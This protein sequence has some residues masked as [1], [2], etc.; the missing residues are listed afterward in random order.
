MSADVPPPA[1]TGLS[2]YSSAVPP[3][4]LAVGDGAEVAGDD[5][6]RHL[7]PLD[8]LGTWV[9][10]ACLELAGERVAVFEQ[11]PDEDELARQGSAGGKW[12]LVYAGSAGVRLEFTKSLVPTRADEG[13][14]YGGNGKEDVIN[15]GHDILRRQLL[16]GNDDPGP[17]QV[18]RLFPPIRRAHADG[19]EYPHTFVGSPDSYDVVPVYYNPT[20]AKPRLQP[21]AVS[22][23]MQPA[24]ER[25]DLYEGLFGDWLPAPCLG[26]PAG[27][28]T[29]WESLVF[30]MPEPPSA[31]MQPVWYRYLRTTAGEVD[32]VHYFDSELPYPLADEPAPEAFYRALAELHRYWSAQFAGGM[33]F[34]LPE[35]WV[36]HFCRH[37][38]VLERATR[39][40]YHPHYGVVDRAYGGPE[41]DGFQDILTS[42]VTCYLEW[43]HFELAKRY[44]DQ[45]L[46]T[47]VRPN[48][49]LR[50]RGPELGQYGRMLAVI[51]RAYELT[52]DEAIL[53]SHHDKIV[54]LSQVLLVRRRQS[55]LRPPDD[56]A[57]G[58]I[59][60]RHEADIS[61]DTPGLLAHDYEQP[62]FC[63]STEAWRGLRDL[64]AAWQ[65]IGRR[66]GDPKLVGQGEQLAGEADRL[67][68][69]VKRAVDRSWVDRQGTSVLPLFPGARALHV[70]A[71]YRSC[72][73]SFDENRVWSEMLYSGLLDRASALAILE[74]AAANGG[75]TLG[76]FGNRRLV[77]SFTAYG[78]AYGM[79]QHDLV[80]EFLLLYYA[81]A[82]HVH[83]RGTWTAFECTD[84]DRDRAEHL[85]YC[86]PAQL[87]VP[88][89]TK[90][91]LV[92]DDPLEPE[93]WLAKAVPRHWLADGLNVRVNGAPTR[94]GPVSYEFSSAVSSGTVRATVDLP[95]RRQGLV[96]L[97]LRVPGR[98]VLTGVEIDGRPSDAFDP[99]HEF[100]AIGPHLSG[101]VEAIAHYELKLSSALRTSPG[102][103]H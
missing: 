54:A 33:Q 18:E 44:L 29:R 21:L 90:W 68:G 73:E 62:Y 55:L 92:F 70:D 87:I 99:V 51:A 75:S 9:L 82:F 83:T 17:E 7:D 89:L 31:H 77:V 103:P 40:G 14:C 86:A 15:G 58:M 5:G 100:I 6:P 22:L 19:Y 42:A 38:M 79:L 61:F 26:Y 41:H 1:G 72:P 63:N 12:R 23:E 10:M 28:G 57:Y 24:I 98:R 43:G 88:T 65:A 85:P 35:Q 93:T 36:S 8:R 45:Y 59:A 16:V 46:A 53:L 64:G 95:E 49:A 50:Y 84:M 91:M 32:E 78:Q 37:S 81:L 25:E 76:I 34:E 56:P 27:N 67:A 66:R 101:R 94:W 2:Q 11:H 71:P 13:S 52:G 20:Q 97:R 48:G 39:T 4:V 96:K 30:A 74:A 3:K 69:D 47:F 102:R 80:R 60:G